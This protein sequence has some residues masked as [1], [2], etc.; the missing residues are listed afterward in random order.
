[1]ATVNILDANN[2][3]LAVNVL[4]PLGLANSANSLP[5]TFAT[6]ASFPALAA[7]TNLIGAVNLDIGGTALSPSN[8]IPMIDAYQAP[9][10][11]TWTTATTVNTAV[12][13]TTS[14][15]DT[16]I[17]SLVASSGFASGVVVFEVYDGTNWLVIKAASI[18]NYTTTGATVVPTASSANGYQ[19][20]VAGFPQFRVRLSTAITAGTLGIVAIIS[21]APD[22]SLVTVGLDPSQ[23]LP[24]GT[25]N[26][27]SVTALG[28]IAAGSADS[29]NGVK[30]SGV[31]VSSL[32]AGT[33]GNRA[34]FTFDT[35][36]K[37]YVTNMNTV[38]TARSV[39]NTSISSPLLSGSAGNTLAPLG[40]APFDFNG[41]GWDPRTKPNIVTRI[42][43]SAANGNQVNLKSTS[44]DLHLFFGQN[45][46]AN[47][48]L[49]VY[50]KASAPVIGTDTPLFPFEIP[51]NANFTQSFPN[52]GLY[53]PLGLSFAFTTDAAGT[54]AAAANAILSFAM[55]AA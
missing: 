14:G 28:N 9:V 32:A 47:T 48:Y 13:Y 51:A 42:V 27:G 55:F 8:P 41:T 2:N 19:I 49:Q 30:V 20:P 11:T 12:T 34:D 26:L 23:A 10:P 50:N 25:N 38:T 21:S 5:V 54:V 46:A 15:Y 43:G 35:R 52:G 4:P 7:G 16:V 45:G 24:A 22:T 44:A 39:L 40:T 53:L 17:I 36:Q 3:F 29:G 6:D 18:L 1:M 37:L 33:A 31:V